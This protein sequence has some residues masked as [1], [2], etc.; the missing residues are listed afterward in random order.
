MKKKIHQLTLAFA[1]LAITSITSHAR[2]P[3]AGITSDSTFTIYYGD[4]YYTNTAGNESI[5]ANWQINW[6][7]INYLRNFDVVVL[8][9]N[10][11]HCTPE[12]IQLIQTDGTNDY[13]DYVLGYI[14]IG[15]DFINDAIESPMSGTGMVE[16]DS[17]GDFVPVAGSTIA[18][19]YM[20]V[21]TQTVTPAI[22]TNQTITSATTTN[23]YA[24]DGEPDLNTVFLG[25]MVNPDANWRY[26]I[27]NMRIG[28]N[29]AV[30]ERTLKAGL[31][32]L[33]GTRDSS[34]LRDRTTNF[35]FDG[36]F[37]DTIDTAG[38]YSGATWYPWTASEMQETVKY[39]SDNYPN[40]TVYANRGAF[41]YTAGL[42][43]PDTGE[44]S[45]DFNIRPY[46]NAFLFES[47]RYDSDVS[48]TGVSPFYNENRY[49]VAPKVMAEANRPDGFTPF[50]LEYESGRT[51]IVDDAF[52]VDVLEFGYTAYYTEG[53]SLDTFDYD[54]YFKLPAIDYLAPTWDSTASVN[55]N[56]VNSNPRIGV[57]RVVP[58]SA[59][60]S[61]TVQW[62]VAI[63]QSYPITYDI[64]VLNLST[65]V[66]TT[67]SNVAFEADPDWYQDPNNNYA[68]QYT[69]SG[70]TV[71]QD[72]NFRVQAK[73]AVGFVNSQDPGT[74]YTIV[75]STTTSNSILS[76]AL[77]IDGLLNDW[78]SLEGYPTDGDDMV[79][80]SDA[81]HISG[82]GNQANWSSIKV[83]NTTDTG[84]IYF[85]Y[86]NYTPIYISWGFQ[87][88]IDTD[89][90]P[91]TGLTVFAGVQLGIGADY[92]IEGVNPWRYTGTGGADWSWVKSEAAGGYEMGRIWA[93]N[94]GEVFCPLSWI[95]NPTSFDFVCFGQNQFYTGTAGEYDWYPDSAVSGDSFR[96]E[97]E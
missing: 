73:D 47:F 96:Y 4:D 2:G 18:S 65:N 6:T 16:L 9:P 92:M 66:T 51:G 30:P 21:E 89:S 82:A 49:N 72:Y 10:Q 70:L 75:S 94:G 78:S 76:S 19:F 80:V 26:V 14:S 62:D 46:V 74:V 39:I 35:G 64:L 84:N 38:P 60:G 1:L 41:F 87:I 40:H 32:Q 63:D 27:D 53:R 61:A 33:A 59:I 22:G 97:A 48:N 28:G 42:Q 69:I 68:N 52:N 71:G 45:T 7:T 24:P 44:Y 85:A 93:G 25:Y 5:P 8:Q 77:T 15:E 50:S 37:L 79:G 81:T 11:P 58:G 54:F 55:Y 31:T 95:G 57:Q 91:N 56:T 29:T 17:N 67:Y 13:V 83:A 34:A 86:E 90:N 12:I 3:M 36:F 23:A 88:L 20:D 43:S